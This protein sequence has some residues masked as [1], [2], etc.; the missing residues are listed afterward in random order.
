M[1]VQD[2]QDVQAFPPLSLFKK[3]KLGLKKT[4]INI[5][6]WFI[7]TM[8]VSEKELEPVP[9]IFNKIGNVL[10]KPFIN[11]DLIPQILMGQ[12]SFQAF[13]VGYELGLFK[14]LNQHRGATLTE[15]AQHLNIELYPAEILVLSLTGF[16]II[17]NINGRYYNTA[18][19]MVVTDNLDNKFNNFLPKYMNYAHHVL[20][21]G[22]QYLEESIRQ[23]KPVGLQKVFG[24]TASD[25]YFELSKNQTANQYFVQ[26][27]S[28]FSQ[29]NA[30]RLASCKIFKR[31]EKLLD[32]GGSVGDVAI[33][34]AKENP[35]I[36]ITVFDHPSVAEIATKNFQQAG[37]ANNLNAVGGNIL[38][39][40]F[41]LNHDGVLFSHFIDIFSVQ[42][43]KNFFKRAFDCLKSQ[44]HIIV[45]T[46]VVNDDQTGPMVNCI[47]GIYFLSLANGKGRFYSAAQIT[48]WMKEVGFV[49]IQ[50]QPLPSY[51]I[52][53]T[54]KKP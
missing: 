44:G 34:I 31:I 24:E 28:A 36:H 15:I 52:I 37:L 45:Y 21:Q 18:V 50:A 53:L 20:A 16:K 25:Y 49:Q 8:K 33:S 22:I 1:I 13:R 48:S 6:Y 41:P 2:V 5:G 39:N 7:R 47:L 27:M 46:P 11:K 26:H 4:K 23:N 32:V 30:Q 35:N 54:A 38:A 19:T 51:E 9:T 17:H 14:Y 40:P 43:N 3:I 42:E 29:I 10:L 12:F